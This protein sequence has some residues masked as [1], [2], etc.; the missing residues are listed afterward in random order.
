MA[1]WKNALSWVAALLLAALFLASGI[2]KI[3]DAPAAAMRMTQAL[4]PEWLSLWVALGFGVVETLSGVLV[5]VPR[6][7]RWGAMLIG[8]MLLAFLAYFAIH[9][10]ALRGADCSCFPWLKRVVG[11]GFFIGDGAM[12]LLALAAGVW[13][14]P[15]EG[16][17]SA[18]LVLSAVL[19]FAMASYGADVVRQ[20]GTKAPASIT[21]DGK[22]YSLQSGK[23]FLF[24]FDPRCSH[25]SEAAKK[26]STLSWGDT[27]IVA[28]PV[29]VPQYAAPFME[30]TGLHAGISS[31]FE[32]LKKVFGYNG[33]PSAIALQNGRQKALLTKFEDAEPNATLQKLGFI[34]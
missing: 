8:L 2:W 17:R 32:A 30:V 23:I 12:L 4:V 6:F 28:V 10:T 18:V 21:V 9:Y 22:P 31:D 33:Y 14:K 26:M 25:C 5:L 20:T 13:T 29:D 15:S 34:R 16:F 24:F 11:P 27:R 7:R 3:T 1:G 19:V